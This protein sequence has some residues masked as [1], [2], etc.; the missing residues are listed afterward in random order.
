MRAADDFGSIRARLAELCRQP[1]ID[2]ATCPQHSFDPADGRCIYCNLHNF[3]LPAF[4]NR[5]PPDADAASLF[6]PGI[7]GQMGAHA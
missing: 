2:P 1:K 6:C 7:A 5:K 3:H 4:L